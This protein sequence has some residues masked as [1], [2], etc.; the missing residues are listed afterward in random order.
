[1]SV[2]LAAAVAVAA[3]A[4]LLVCPPHLPGVVHSS[5]VS[6]VSWVR[7]A[8]SDDTHVCPSF[9]SRSSVPSAAPSCFRQAAHADSPAVAWLRDLN[10]TAVGSSL[11]ALIADL[12]CSEYRLHSLDPVRIPLEKVQRL[13]STAAGPFLIEIGR[14]ECITGF[15]MLSKRLAS[16]RHDSPV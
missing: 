4:P 7:A 13:V 10:E 5:I 3:K 12:R 6:P 9:S 2:H 1:M 14:L 11:L 16:R 15:S 8:R